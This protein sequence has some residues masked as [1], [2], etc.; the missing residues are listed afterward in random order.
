MGY[1]LA[2]LPVVIVCVTA[3]L[4]VRPHHRQLRALLH[5]PWRDQLRAIR[6]LPERAE[7]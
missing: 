7:R 3:Y 6:R 5:R 2:A 1:A 4:S